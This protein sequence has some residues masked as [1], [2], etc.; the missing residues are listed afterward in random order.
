MGR[1]QGKIKLNRFQRFISRNRKPERGPTVSHSLTRV[2]IHTVLGTNYRQR[3][4]LPTFEL[5]LHEHIK[6][7][8]E[9]DFDSPV[10]AINGVADH[11]HVLFLLSP[12]YAM[13]DLLQNIKGESSHWVNQQDFAK[14]KF[15]WQTG[16]AAFSV[17]ESAVFEVERYIANQK[18]HH[19]KKGF[20]EE[21]EELLREHGVEPSLE[22]VETVSPDD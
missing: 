16:Y 2:W 3:T 20:A 15:A 4:I 5:S 9:E 11:I 13:K 14:F 7:H 8:L 18:Q 22:T 17:S 12:H 6:R 1:K 21:W 19:A 10:R